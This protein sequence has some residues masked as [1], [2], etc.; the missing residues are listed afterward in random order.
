MKSIMLIFLSLAIFNSCN[1]QNSKHPIQKTWILSDQVAKPNSGF[2]S[3]ISG[4]LLHFEGDTLSISNVFGHETSKNRFSVK[5]KFIL[6]DTSVIG[7]ILHLSKDSLIIEQDS[8]TFD[9]HF[10]PLDDSQISLTKNEIYQFL[11]DSIWEL[12]TEQLGKHRIYLD[13]ASWGGQFENNIWIKHLFYEFDIGYGKQLSGYEYWVLKEFEGKYIFGF[14]SGQFDQSFFQLTSIGE[15]N[16]NGQ[17]LHHLERDWLAA[18]LLTIRSEDEFTLQNLYDTICGEWFI[19]SLIFPNRDSLKNMRNTDNIS[20]SGMFK[21]ENRVTVSD[22]EEKNIRFEFK[23]NGSY[24]IYAEDK[25]LRKGDK[26]GLIND[27][28]FLYLDYKISGDNLIE[29]IDFDNQLLRI[30]KYEYIDIEKKNR[31]S[32]YVFDILEIEL[33]KK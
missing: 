31:R 10:R 20:G 28:R 7:K 15:N 25:L 22:L 2:M 26:W 11:V 17:L 16:I 33:R 8:L 21:Y 9:M 1:S 19:D 27:G 5:N 3:I 14:S 12:E 4:A 24:N 29:I 30:R 6:H 23:K 13:T 32:H 18:S